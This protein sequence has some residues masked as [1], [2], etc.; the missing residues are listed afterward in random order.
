MQE[1]MDTTSVAL[2]GTKFSANGGAKDSGIPFP[3]PVINRR[4]SNDIPHSSG[5][6][7]PAAKRVKYVL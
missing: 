5:G 4:G 1:N 7:E 2:G 3:P 6:Y